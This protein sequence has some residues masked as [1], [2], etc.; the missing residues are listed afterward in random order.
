MTE[1]LLRAKV[2]ESGHT[3]VVHPEVVVEVLFGDVQKSPQYPCGMAL[4]FAR[5]ARIRDDKHPTEVDSIETVR[6]IRA[7]QTYPGD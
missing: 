3:V 5:I 1:R 4:R 6:E 2:R 7:R